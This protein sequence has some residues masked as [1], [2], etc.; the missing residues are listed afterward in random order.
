MSKELY[1]VKLVKS[2]IEL[3]EPIIV[4]VFV[5]QFAKL[6]L[7]E[8]YNFVWEALR[9]HDYNSFKADAVQ[10]SFREIVVINI[11][12]TINANQVCSRKSLDVLK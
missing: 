9:E 6:R 3:R 10:N 5:H 7:L 2:N 1:E 11:K 4:D 12:S 8:L